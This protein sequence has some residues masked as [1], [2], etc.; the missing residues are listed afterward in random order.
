MKYLIIL[1]L[2]VMTTTLQAQQQKEPKYTLE[3]SGVL[4][5]SFTTGRLMMGVNLDVV[6][7]EKYVFESSIISHMNDH[8][9]TMAQEKLGVR[10]KHWT[11]LGGA[12]Y[13]YFN[14]T[15]TTEKSEWKFMTEVKYSLYL[16]KKS[17]G[18]TL[19]ND[20]NY[21]SLGVELGAIL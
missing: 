2:V 12:S 17:L 18:F 20:G 16:F 19:Q 11:I 7:K 13:H 8:Y 9:P 1:L 21:V 15:F 5:T 14:N 10:S 3:A 4:A 6:R